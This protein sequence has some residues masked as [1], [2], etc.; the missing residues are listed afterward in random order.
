MF[1]S[2]IPTQLAQ[3]AVMLKGA[4]TPQQL[5][6]V[7]GEPNASPE[8][9][10][11][12]AASAGGMGV[13]KAAPAQQQIAAQQQTGNDG[14][15]DDD[16]TDLAVLH[17]QRL[18]SFQ[19]GLR[20]CT[21]LQPADTERLVATHT[22]QFRNAVF[23]EGIPGCTPGQS[24]PAD[25]FNN[26]AKKW[27]KKAQEPV[28]CVALQRVREMASRLRKQNRGGELSSG[29]CTAGMKFKHDTKIHSRKYSCEFKITRV[30]ANG[31]MDIG[32]TCTPA[33]DN[34]SLQHYREVTTPPTQT[35]ENCGFLTADLCTAA[36]TTASSAA[37]AAASAAIRA[38]AG[39][40]AV[41]AAVQGQIDALQVQHQAASAA[42]QELLLKK[43]SKAAAVK[44]AVKG[45]CAR[46]P[47]LTGGF[48]GELAC[49]VNSAGVCSGPTQPSP[50][51]A[52]EG[53]EALRHE[54]QVQYGVTSKSKGVPYLQGLLRKAK[55]KA[56]S[57]PAGQPGAKVPKAAAPGAGP[58]GGSICTFKATKESSWGKGAW[59]SCVI[60]HG[61]GPAGKVMMDY[62][63]AAGGYEAYALGTPGAMKDAGGGKWTWG[64][65]HDCVITRG[66]PLPSSAM[67]TGYT[68][69]AWQV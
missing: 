23:G 31:T 34:T 58:A 43:A 42:V 21:F 69:S 2:P 6:E 53:A 18:S 56:A 50:A 36:A 49:A 30:H 15:S 28:A 10:S 39:A 47:L 25:F 9:Q 33:G 38:A 29:P 17:Q 7:F 52:A 19:T 5:V 11:T 54:L 16:G 46:D 27:A 24:V 62:H 35:A 66:T 57:A 20:S 40:C 1:S 37:A 59:A 55:T 68:V 61:T 63:N 65:P 64:S 13:K 22:H 48:R 3:I 12:P 26:A 51:P 44:A 8:S 4:L 67:G 41:L 60:R 32:V 45:A 14:D